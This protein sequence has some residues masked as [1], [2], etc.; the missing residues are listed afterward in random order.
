MPRFRTLTANQI[1]SKSHP[2]DLV[3]IADIETEAWLTPRLQNL[4][5]GSFVLGEE[6]HARGDVSHTVLAQEAPVWLIDPVDGTYNFAHGNNRFCSM[7]SLVKNCHV[8]A[9]WI[10]FPVDGRLYWAGKDA[11]A[12]V[13]QD[14]EMWQSLILDQTGDLAAISWRLFVT[15]ELKQRKRQILTA[16]APTQPTGC[17]GYDYRWRRGGDFGLYCDGKVNALG[18]C[19]RYLANS[20]GRRVR[21]SKW[22]TL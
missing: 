9:G 17:A 16:L 4:L 15:E 1:Q 8:L 3:T 11:G 7:V 21:P 18:P 10:Y 19:S 5:P 22:W 20:S 13:Q 12:H 2:K 14:G 6:A